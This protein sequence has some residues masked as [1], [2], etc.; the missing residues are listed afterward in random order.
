MR[1]L[2]RYLRSAQNRPAAR[3][4]EHG[5]QTTATRRRSTGGPSQGGRDY[6]YRWTSSSTH[7]RRRRKRT[8]TVSGV[9]LCVSLAFVFGPRRAASMRIPRPWS[10]RSSCEKAVD[11]GWPFVYSKYRGQ[12]VCGA[13]VSPCDTWCC[14]SFG[15]RNNSIERNTCHA[16]TCHEHSCIDT[17]NG[18]ETP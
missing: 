8:V 6:L 18:R 11:P 3:E 14:P 12:E 9:A 16:V 5:D 7:T 2:L 13:A 1:A 4:R 10:E 17:Y 15:P